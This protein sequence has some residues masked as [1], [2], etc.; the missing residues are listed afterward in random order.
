MR[1]LIGFALV[2]A[3]SACAHMADANAGDITIAGSRIHPESLT[4]DAAGNL[5]NGSTA[6][7]IYRTLAG[8]DRAEPW[9]V[10]DATNG[11]R[12]LFG[13]LADD[14]RG[15]LWVCDNP[16]LF[17]RQTGQSVVRAFRLDSGAFVAAY[18]MPETGPAACNDLAVA[19]DGTVWVSETSG[20]RIFTLAPGAQSLSLFAQSPDLVGID[21]LAFAGDG[22]LYINN[23]RQQLFQR[24]ERRP[25]GA[26]AGLTNLAP[27]QPLAG[28]DGLRPLGGNRF[29]QGEGGNGRVAL[30]EVGE[31]A[32]HVT[33]LAEGLDGPVGVTVHN[34]TVYVVEGKI[35]YLF[36]Q[37]LAGQSPDPFLIRAFSLPPAP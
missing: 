23:V 32:V 27:S 28:P 3:L 26:F 37:A 22:R 18:G 13:V 10:P 21:G 29:V 4:S 31:T 8:S 7:T 17:A 20:G 5:Y 9:I 1:G 35:N 2:A 24:V 12:S 15:L 11:L 19:H 36:D 14:A 16:N 6:G 33:A 25:D 34:G 30:L